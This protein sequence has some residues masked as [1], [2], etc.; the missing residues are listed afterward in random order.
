MRGKALLEEMSLT[1]SETA[2]SAVSVFDLF[3]CRCRATGERI[4]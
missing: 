2:N 3:I 4:P 1:I